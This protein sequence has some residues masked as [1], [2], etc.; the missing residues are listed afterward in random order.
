VL[1]IPVQSVKTANKKPS[2]KLES[3]EIKNIITWFTDWK[4]VE[5]VSWLK[6]GD[7]ILY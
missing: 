7:K 1:I 6:L 3:W 4:M 2:V 5:V